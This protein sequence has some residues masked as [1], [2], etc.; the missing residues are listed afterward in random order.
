MGKI[1]A[2][3]DDKLE[4]AFRQKILVRKRNKKGAL[5]DSLEEAVKLWLER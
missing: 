3:I 5:R 4:M 2:E 1:I